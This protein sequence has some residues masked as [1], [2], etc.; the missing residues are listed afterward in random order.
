M[1]TPWLTAQF[2]GARACHIRGLYCW[3]I[4][5][6]ADPADPA[7]WDRADQITFMGVPAQQAVASCFSSWSGG[8]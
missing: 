1:Q 6:T 5:F 8:K 3:E 2:A 7:P 4:N